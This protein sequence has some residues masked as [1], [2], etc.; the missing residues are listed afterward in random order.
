MRNQV[1]LDLQVG[2]YKAVKKAGNG[3]KKAGA[4]LREDWYG[5]MYYWLG[6][7]YDKTRKDA[8]SALNSLSSSSIGLTLLMVQMKLEGGNITGAIETMHKLL[9]E[10]PDEKKYLPG[11][12]GL[13]VA[14]YRQQGRKE[15]VRNLLSE[16]SEYSKKT[17]QPVSPT[18][19]RPLRPLP[20]HLT[21][22]T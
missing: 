3:N 17:E 6:F 20:A 22:T 15:D 16:A 21:P 5:D 10:L 7:A 8:L 13:L 4:Y 19:L 14:L 1:S 2:K 12:V 18:P 9:A 11:L